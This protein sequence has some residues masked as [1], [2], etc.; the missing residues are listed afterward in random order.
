MEEGNEKDIRKKKAM[1]KL[2]MHLDGR[3]QFLNLLKQINDGEQTIQLQTELIEDLKRQKDSGTIRLR[4]KFGNILN[5]KD[6]PRSITIYEMDLENMEVQNG[7]FK[8][9]LFHAING[10]DSALQGKTIAELKTYLANHYDLMDQEYQKVK[11]V[12]NS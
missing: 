7:Y 2:Q 3:R 4:D 9:D 10:K 6:L 11:K 8:E 1:E 5:I 12:M